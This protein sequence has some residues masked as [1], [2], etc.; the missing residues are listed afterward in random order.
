MLEDSTAGGNSGGKRRLRLLLTSNRQ[1]PNAAI[2]LPPEAKLESAR[3]EGQEVPLRSSHKTGPRM[4]E[5]WTELAMLTMR[6]EGVEMEI[7]LGAAQPL[8]W[9]VYD[10]SPG[11]PP[12]G[13]P[14]L[15]AR[16]P[17]AVTFQDGD[18]TLVAR[19]LRI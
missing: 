12:A 17:S 4:M 15:K 18:T 5:G 9:Y 2:L 10:M 6:P 16:L 7:V 19:K 11:L 13:D 3:V 8:D 14:L 1:A